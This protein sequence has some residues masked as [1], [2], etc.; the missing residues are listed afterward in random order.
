[1]SDLLSPL[2]MVIQDD[3]VFQAFVG[4]MNRTVCTLLSKDNYTTNLAI[5]EVQLL[6][7][8]I[9]DASTIAGHGYPFAIHGSQFI[10]AF[11]AC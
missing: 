8:P 3:L 9:R 5:V 4:F 6:Y 11:P 7:G 2:Y 1:M 10:Q